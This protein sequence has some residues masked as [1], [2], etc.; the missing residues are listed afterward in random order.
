MTSIDDW[1]FA[2]CTQLE[3]VGNMQNLKSTGKGV[4]GRITYRDDAGQAIR[5]DSCVPLKS[6]GNMPKLETIGD[7]AFTNA[8]RLQQWAQW[9]K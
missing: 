4:F 7:Y 8:V 5:T 1:A 2:G 3:T 6:I 9:A